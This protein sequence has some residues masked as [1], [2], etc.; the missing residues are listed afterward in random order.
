MLLFIYLKKNSNQIICIEH[1]LPFL[2]SSFQ[3]TSG[4]TR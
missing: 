3:L 4:I 1:G 2:E